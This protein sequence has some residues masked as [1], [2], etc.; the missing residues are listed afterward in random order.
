MASHHIAPQLVMAGASSLGEERGPI[1][2][3]TILFLVKSYSR[4]SSYGGELVGRHVESV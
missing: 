2:L 4:G 1:P 3:T